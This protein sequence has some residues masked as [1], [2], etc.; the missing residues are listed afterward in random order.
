M[1]VPGP[2]HIVLP[3]DEVSF[4]I[5][6][7]VSLALPDTRAHS[8][9]ALASLEKAPI[10][11]VLLPV[12]AGGVT[13]ADGLVTVLGVALAAAGGLLAGAGGTATGL[14]GT[15][16]TASGHGRGPA[17]LAGG[18]GGDWC[19]YTRAAREGVSGGRVRGLA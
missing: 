18:R 5:C 9:S 6:L 7:A 10:C 8:S 16:F 19:R 2:R 4:W 17:G 1:G 14:V 12:A 15:G 11:T 3:L 13:G